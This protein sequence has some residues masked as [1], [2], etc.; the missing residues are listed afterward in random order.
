MAVLPHL[1]LPQSWLHALGPLLAAYLCISAG[2]V[3]RRRLLPT[4]GVIALGALLGY[5]SQRPSRTDYRHLLTG[6]QPQVECKVSLRADRLI[7]ADDLRALSD[8][9][10]IQASLQAIRFDPGQP[11]RPCSGTLILSEPP[12]GAKLG[13]VLQ[14]TGALREALPA[15][16]PGMFDYRRYLRLKGIYHILYPDQLSILPDTPGWKTRQ[17]RRLVLL[18]EHLLAAA[19]SG[20]SPRHQPIIAAM[21][22]GYRQAL[23]APLKQDYI[24]SGMIHLFAISGLH[25]GILFTFLMLAQAALR[26][27]WQWRFVIAPLL[28]LAYVIATGAPASAVRAWLMLTIWSAARAANRP[29]SPI[30]SLF[31]A[32]LIILLVSPTQL[33]QSGFQF[34]CLVVLFLL[35]GWRAADDLLRALQA[36][37]NW[38]P[39][40]LRPRQWCRSA[41]L[42]WLISAT[43]AVLAAWLGSVGLTAYYNHLLIPGGLACNLVATSLAWLLML[44]VLCKIP[45]SAIGLPGFDLFVAS[46]MERIMDLLQSLAHLS[47]DLGGAVGTPHPA[48]WLVAAYYAACSLLLFSRVSIPRRTVIAVATGT[49]IAVLLIRPPAETWVFVPRYSAVPVVIIE[50]PDRPPTLINAGAADGVHALT[51][52]LHARG[53]RRIET[54]WLLDNRSDHLAASP[55]L[56]SE[57]RS[58]TLALFARDNFHIPALEATAWNSD[59]RYRCWLTNAYTSPSA[60]YLRQQQKS[61]TYLDF[62]TQQTRLNLQVTDFRL[63]NLRL[64]SPTS[65]L[66]LQLDE[67]TPH[68]RWYRFE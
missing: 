45:F 48:I 26:V 17:I 32:A 2:L 27:P 61:R 19:V 31:A 16:F 23:P 49:I 13:Q 42:R 36:D 41:A 20:L 66:S 43:V 5:L 38:V 68:N 28:L 51:A 44:G 14:V 6:L 22:F 29:T 67:Q 55:E 15:E 3:D 58:D 59:T 54:I 8:T 64:R 21:T 47:R 63:G 56:A 11:W 34:S 57:I 35:R 37:Q 33:F 1:A 9:R 60:R 62:Q 24:E 12:A 39:A 53:H 4:A 25:V 50:Q 10:Q 46:S 18:R 65:S 52:W 30:N 7:Q 40:R